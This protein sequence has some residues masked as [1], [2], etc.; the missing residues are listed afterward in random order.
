MVSETLQIPIVN[1]DFKQYKVNQAVFFK[2]NSIKLTIIAVHINNCTI[3]STT[4][5][6]IEQT[7]MAIHKHVEITD[8]GE[9]HWLLGIEIIRNR[10]T[11]TIHLSQKSYIESIVHQFN[12]EDAHTVSTPMETHI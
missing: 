3:A 6:L 2:C 12:L 1:M 8:L 7:K 11:R 9:L 5:L 4:I 10:E